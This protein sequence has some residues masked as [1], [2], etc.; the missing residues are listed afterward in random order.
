M[1]LNLHL[2][3]RESKPKLSPKLATDMVNYLTLYDMYLKK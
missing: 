3:V 1:S 2:N